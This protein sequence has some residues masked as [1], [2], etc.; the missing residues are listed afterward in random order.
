MAKLENTIITPWQ[1]DNDYAITKSGVEKQDEFTLEDYLDNPSAGSANLKDTG[2]QFLSQTYVGKIQNYISGL[3]EKS[4]DNGSLRPKSTVN[5]SGDSI[6]LDFKKIKEEK[7]K[8]VKLTSKLGQYNSAMNLL[9]IAS[10]MYVGTLGQGGLQVLDDAIGMATQSL[11]F[12]GL[13]ANA[14]TAVSKAIQ[15]AKSNSNSIPTIVSKDNIVELAIANYYTILTSKPGLKIK[16]YGNKLEYITNENNNSILI[17]KEELEEYKNKFNFFNKE[18]KAGKTEEYYTTGTTLTKEG[19]LKTEKIESSETVINSALRK[20]VN[21]VKETEELTD[22]ELPENIKDFNDFFEKSYEEYFG[23]KYGRNFPRVTKARIFNRVNNIYRNIGGLYVEPFMN[24]AG[25]KCYEIPFEFNPT[26]TEGSQSAKYNTT[27]VLGRIQSLKSYVSSDASTVSIEADYL[28]LAEE[29]ENSTTTVSTERKHMN[30]K[31]DWVSGWMSDWTTKRLSIIERQFRSLTLP[32][33]NKSEFVRPPIVRI[34]MRSSSLKGDRGDGKLDLD[35]KN[36]LKIG[37]LFR[38]PSLGG[39]GQEKIQITHK[40]ENR[41]RDKRYVVTNITITPLSQYGNSYF[42]GTNGI[43]SISS[44]SAY[45]NS[46]KRNGFKVKIDLAETTKNFLDLLP[47]YGDYING[48]ES[49]DLAYFNNDMDYITAAK[50]NIDLWSCLNA[51][52]KMNLTE[53]NSNGYLFPFVKDAGFVKIEKDSNEGKEKEEENKILIPKENTDKDFKEYKE[54]LYNEGLNYSEIAELLYNSNEWK[55]KNDFQTWLFD[56]SSEDFKDNWGEYYTLLKKLGIEDKEIYKNVK[57]KWRK[58]IKYVDEFIPKIDLQFNEYLS[59][60]TEIFEEESK[61]KSKTISKSKIISKLKNSKFNTMPQNEDDIDERNKF[62]NFMAEPNSLFSNFNELVDESGLSIGEIIYLC[63]GSDK[64]KEQIGYKEYYKFE[65]TKEFYKWLLF[66]GFDDHK[67]TTKEKIQFYLSRN[68]LEKTI[69]EIKSVC[70]EEY[71]IYLLELI[72]YVSYLT[73]EYVNKLCNYIEELSSREDVIFNEKSEEYLIEDKYNIYAYAIKG[74]RK[75][76]SNLSKQK[77]CISYLMEKGK[78]K[79][80]KNGWKN[81][82]DYKEFDETTKDVSNDDNYNIGT[83]EQYK[84]IEYKYTEESIEDD[85]DKDS[86]NLIGEFYDDKNYHPDDSDI[87]DFIDDD[88]LNEYNA[89]M[90][91]VFFKNSN[92]K[93]KFCVCEDGSEEKRFVVEEKKEDNTTTKKSENVKKNEE[94]KENENGK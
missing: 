25:L 19:I 10:G 69:E 68:S 77:L 57:G 6:G 27:E 46:V 56:G 33:I 43:S 26:I 15:T 67:E 36:N 87:Q 76:V 51:P 59:I 83:V 41:T 13:A 72:L 30:K 65:Q 91:L 58:N 85:F 64:Q 50:D 94:S 44:N 52:L 23:S 78:D 2:L 21:L 38:Y 11:P 54:E 79:N 17:T 63:S 42:Y 49:E 71:L 62:Q 48:E 55:T 74:I 8:N 18:E 80:D 47:N 22:Y 5:S 84:E 34:K 37:D 89:Q 9:G 92:D 28:A 40:Y 61:E 39:N 12:A 82:E 16:S 53:I 60:L 32:Y 1:S 75:E 93:N 86:E 73:K 31:N 66:D 4:N 20:E 3:N 14:A 24:S 35:D 7:Y 90:F 88:F 81:R 29:F 70:G 45:Y